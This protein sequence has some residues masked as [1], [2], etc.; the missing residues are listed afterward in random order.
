M[1]CIETACKG[2]FH[3]KSAQV[4]ELIYH[5]TI[6]D[7]ILEPGRGNKVQMGNRQWAISKWDNV[8]MCKK[9]SYP[10]P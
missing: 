9:K 8:Q 1:H 10:I 3:Q 2:G 4:A 6:N 5:L 7:F